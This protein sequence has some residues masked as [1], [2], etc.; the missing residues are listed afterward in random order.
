M[1]GTQVTA[2]RMQVNTFVPLFLGS[3]SSTASQQWR[4]TTYWLAR[5][6]ELSLLM[7]WRRVLPDE[8]F[9]YQYSPKPGI[10]RIGRGY[11]VDS[12]ICLD[13]HQN[14]SCLRS[15]ELEDVTWFL[16]HNDAEHGIYPVYSK[17]MNDSLIKQLREQ[18]SSLRPGVVVHVTSK[19]SYV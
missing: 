6:C 2:E 7:S 4:Y 5:I 18:L 11:A 12:K 8:H 3:D 17:T 1:E 10:G 9:A 13:G 14:C 19:L 16:Q 15:K